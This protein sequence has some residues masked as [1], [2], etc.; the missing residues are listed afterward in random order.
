MRKLLIISFFICTI[1]PLG[2]SQNYLTAGQVYNFNVGDIFETE[3]G[4]NPPQGVPIFGL[5]IVLG[6]WYS[7]H[8]DTVYYR[9]SV[10]SYS[11]PVCPPPCGS[12][13]FSTSIDTVS[14]TNLNAKAVQDTV[15]NICPV[16]LDSMYVTSS[17]DCWQ[18]NWEVGPG[19]NCLDT[20]HPTFD[21]YN[22]TY[23]WLIEGCGG[24]YMNIQFA[25]YDYTCYYTL[26]YSKKHDTVCGSEY[27]ITGTNQIKPAAS[28]L[29]LQPNPSN[30]IFTLSFTTSDINA[31]RYKTY[32]I[33]I[34]NV[35]GMLIYSQSILL[36]SPYTLDLHSQPNG[37]YFYRITGENKNLIGEGK[38]VI[39]K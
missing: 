37:V 17:V 38:L 4:T 2:F 21:G 15:P 24:P 35:L 14:Y 33:E 22:I 9:D 31:D 6:K 20:L 3:S 29:K 34:Y 16:S 11:P 30:G 12:G 13:A 26:I 23:S 39:Q 5:T 19:K 7:A 8:S 36:T 28:D 25:G 18:K 10:V 1:V 27:I 32:K